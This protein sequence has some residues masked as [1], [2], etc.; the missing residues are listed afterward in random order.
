MQDDISHDRVRAI[1]AMIR[2]L[3]GWRIERI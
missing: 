3:K 2:F 1:A